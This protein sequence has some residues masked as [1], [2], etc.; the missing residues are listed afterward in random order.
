MTNADTITPDLVSIMKRGA[1]D[2]QRNFTSPD[3]DWAPVMIVNG[4]RG[5]AVL[6]VPIGDDKNLTAAIITEALRSYQATEAALVTSSWTVQRETM[7]EDDLPVSQ[8]PDRKEVLVLTYVSADSAEMSMADIVRHVDTP[9]TLGE[10][11]EQ[12]GGPFLSG[13]FADALRKGIG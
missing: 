4:P 9:P 5:V 11:S 10:W 7:S 6:M 2:V 12:M 3:D 1:A 13:L 8:Q